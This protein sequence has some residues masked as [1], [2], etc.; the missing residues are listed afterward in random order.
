MLGT[1]KVDTIRIGPFRPSI[2]SAS[3]W[4]ITN[5]PD[6]GTVYFWIYSDAGNKLVAQTTG[7]YSKKWKRVWLDFTDYGWVTKTVSFSMFLKDDLLVFLYYMNTSI[8]SFD[9]FS[10]S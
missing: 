6:C 5:G 2:K 7:E 10:V 4:I 1:A 3:F 9:L 8:R